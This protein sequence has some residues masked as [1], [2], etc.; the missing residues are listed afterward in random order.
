MKRLDDTLCI[1]VGHVEGDPSYEY[2]IILNNDGELTIRELPLV[3]Y[4]KYKLELQAE[5]FFSWTRSNELLNGKKTLTLT[6]NLSM[7]TG[8][9]DRWGDMDYKDTPTKITF[10]RIT[11]DVE[12]AYFDNK[13]KGFDTR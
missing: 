13:V 6:R 1:F 3:G 5:N 11:L 7:P 2:R 8:E 4:G 9:R 10:K 12:I